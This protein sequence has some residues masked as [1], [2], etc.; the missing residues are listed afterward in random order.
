MPITAQKQRYEART[1]RRKRRDEKIRSLYNR[2]YHED[3]K[4]IDDV[5]KEVSEFWEISTVTVRKI[6]RGVV[7]C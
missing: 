4:R 2:L 1:E 5:E 3:R 6:L 7:I